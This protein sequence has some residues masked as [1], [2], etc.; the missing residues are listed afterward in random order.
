[1][2]LNSRSTS[3]TCGEVEQ[4]TESRPLMKLAVLVFDP[5]PVAAGVLAMQL[6][7]AG[8]ATYVTSSGT[9]AISSAGQRQFAAIVVIAD[10]A[11]SQMRDCLH[12]IRDADPDA[13]LV[14]ISDPTLDGACRVAYEL[15]VDARI[16]MPFTVSDLAQRLSVLRARAPLVA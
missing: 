3:L 5:E 7:R 11:D 12:K 13:W 2:S 16:D 8:F 1:M 10:L 6:R 15:G 9:A 14:V 4:R